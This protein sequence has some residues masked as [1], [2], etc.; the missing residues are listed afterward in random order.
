MGAAPNEAGITLGAQMGAPSGD[1]THAGLTVEAG[2]RPEYGGL[3]M[4]ADSVVAVQIARLL[5]RAPAA[6]W[7]LVETT[8]PARDGDVIL[9]DAAGTPVAY[10]RPAT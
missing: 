1:R 5:R 7:E 10:A 2:S 9:Y 8:E 3:A 6:V 4:A